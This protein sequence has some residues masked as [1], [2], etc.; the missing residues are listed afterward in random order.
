MKV[1]LAQGK[2]MAGPNGTAVGGDI[3]EV[4]KEEGEQ[5]VSSHQ[6]EL[7]EPEPTVAPLELETAA[8]EPQGETAEAPKRG[9]KRKA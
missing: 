8:A 7:V 9:R 1:R 3:I 5:L 2:I 4:S 6:A